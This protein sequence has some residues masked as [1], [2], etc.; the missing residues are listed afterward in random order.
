MRYPVV[1]GKLADGSIEAR[2]PDVPGAITCGSDEKEALEMALDCLLTLFNGFIQDEEDIPQP[3]PMARG[4]KAVEVPVMVV[5]KL[6][7]YRAMRESGISRAGLAQK[8][9]CEVRQ[10]KRLL[11]VFHSSRFDRMESVL[12]TLGYRPTID[13]EKVA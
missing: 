1:L 7:V 5:T 3:S 11:D 13:V 8:V 10:I 4:K 12:R 9:G 6:A 2:I